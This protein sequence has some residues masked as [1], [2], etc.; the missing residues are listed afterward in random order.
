MDDPDKA[1]VTQSGDF[2]SMILCVL[3]DSKCL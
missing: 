3:K 2:L 1:A